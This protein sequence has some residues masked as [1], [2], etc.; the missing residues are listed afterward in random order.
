[1]DALLGCTAIF[2]GSGYPVMVEILGQGP[3]PPVFDPPAVSV[4]QGEVIVELEESFNDPGYDIR[5]SA[6]DE[7]PSGAS[8]QRQV[9]IDVV[10]KRLKGDF[11]AIVWSR[12][13]RFTVGWV[14]AGTYAVRL[15]WQND[16]TLPG[17]RSRVLVDT[18]VTVP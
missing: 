17:Y 3:S 6:R 15:H 11:V 8:G 18:V 9:S 10:T 5:A 1:L 7:R 12:T 13:Y 4:R 2:G 16:F 14:P